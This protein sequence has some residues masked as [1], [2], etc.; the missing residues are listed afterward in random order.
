MQSFILQ[1]LTSENYLKA[2]E[3]LSLQ[4][5]LYLIDIKLLQMDINDVNIFKVILKEITPIVKPLLSEY[6]GSNKETLNSIIHK[7]FNNEIIDSD[8][9]TSKSL[10]KFKEA[11]LKAYKIVCPDLLDFPEG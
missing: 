5:G 2:I 3:K 8:K 7:C 9:L 6:S 4:E 10:P 11:R 1:L